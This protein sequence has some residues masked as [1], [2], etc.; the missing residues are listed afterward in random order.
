M[1]ALDFLVENNTFLKTCIDNSKTDYK[2]AYT[3]RATS[4][5]TDKVYKDELT[6]KFYCPIEFPKN[7]F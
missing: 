3:I 5:N 6:G 1:Q 7:S 2:F 4:P